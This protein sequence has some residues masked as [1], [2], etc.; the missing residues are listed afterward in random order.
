MALT[1]RKSTVMLHISAEVFRPAARYEVEDYVRACSA[2]VWRA[3][4][5]FRPHRREFH[6][7]RSIVRADD[8]ALDQ[9]RG[10]IEAAE[11]RGED[12]EQLQVASRD[13]L[14]L[15]CRRGLK[16]AE[17]RKTFAKLLAEHLAHVRRLREVRDMNLRALRHEK[18]SQHGRR[19]P[20]AQSHQPHAYAASAKRA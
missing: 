5:Q 20:Q 11:A 18:D 8:A 17:A 2:R 1:Q 3:K 19:S 7:L 4:R 15:R 13:R 12:T 14:R 16:L 10:E 6:A 9:L